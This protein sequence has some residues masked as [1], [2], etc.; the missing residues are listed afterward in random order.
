M[1]PKGV[2]RV[3]IAVRDLDKA[4]ALYSRLFDTPFHERDAS[5]AASY[6]IRASVNWDAAI[7]IV[8]P[9][10]ESKAA[11]GRDVARF[12]D[13]CG[14]GLY[15]VVF[16]VDNIDEAYARATEMSIHIAGSFEFD[17][18]QIDRLLDGRFKKFK[19]YTLR[20]A[21]TCGVRLLFGQY[22]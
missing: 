13:K 15:S 16:S 5:V 21:D 20:A 9:L 17:Q 22:E 11:M 7:E 6:G 4:M 12:L 14:E 18:E 10:P 8:S 2:S 19:Q 1:K 3:V